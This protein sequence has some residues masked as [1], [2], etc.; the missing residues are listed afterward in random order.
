MTFTIP[1][2]EL[3]Y[4]FREGDTVVGKLA[5]EVPF[6]TLS[7]ALTIPAN[8]VFEL[9]SAVPFTHD[10]EQYLA[11]KYPPSTGTEGRIPLPANFSQLT[12]QKTLDYLRE[13]AS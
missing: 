10:K 3:S 5:Q 2:S 12:W 1:T 4:L 8:D 13:Q 7:S 11:V 6:Q 9:T